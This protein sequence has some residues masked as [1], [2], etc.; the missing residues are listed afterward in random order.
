MMFPIP[1]GI[2][3][4]QQIQAANLQGIIIGLLSAIGVLSF[5]IL[6]VV[7]RLRAELRHTSPHPHKKYEREEL[8]N[9]AERWGGL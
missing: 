7:I 6:F 5:A 1:A 4:E 8:E 9:S 3:T 2:L